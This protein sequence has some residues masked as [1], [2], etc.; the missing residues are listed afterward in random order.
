MIA[1]NEFDRIVTGFYAA[2][3]GQISWDDALYPIHVLFR[4]RVAIIQSVDISTGK[5]VQLSNGG[6]A[7]PQA[8]LEYIR[9]WHELD[10]RRA[11][12]LSH[13]PELIGRWW[14][15]QDY[16]D[17]AFASRNPFYRE[18]LVGQQTRF[19]ATSL[20]QPSSDTL[21]AFG[22]ELPAERGPLNIDERHLIERLGRYFSDAMCAY[23]RVRRLT[24]TALA[25]HALL[26]T[27][28]YPMWL[29]DA[30]RVV[31]HGNPAAKALEIEGLKLVVTGRRLFWHG[32]SADRRLSEI[33]LALGGGIQH[34]HREVVDARCKKGDSLCWLHMHV[35][36]PS[37]VLGFAFGNRPM[38]VLTLFDPSHMRELDPFALS[39]VFGMT[40]AEGRVAALLSEGLSAKEIGQRLGCRETT[41]RTHLRNVLHKLGASRLSDAVRLL[42][43]G[44]T[45]WSRPLA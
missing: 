19:L 27:F 5:I 33:L 6:D 16:F 44:E 1:E 3:T 35:L 41:V 34:G 45:L 8:F 40:P 21:T 14:H 39:E 7:M 28:A 29:L 30:D 10:P 26:D 20:H 37:R 36:D 13:A 43:Q 9:K 2:A 32:A 22:L 12:I 38:L 31:L 23:E 25:G 11:H 4:A 15:C 42:R 24:S 18:F 17:E